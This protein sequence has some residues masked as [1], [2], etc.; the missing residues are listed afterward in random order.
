MIFTL[1][2]GKSEK[3]KGKF[4]KCFMRKE[5]KVELRQRIYMMEE[6]YNT[7]CSK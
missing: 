5:E 4:V 3:K 2:K 6:K 7:V 1:F